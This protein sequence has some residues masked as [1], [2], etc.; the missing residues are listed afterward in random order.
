MVPDD[1]ADLADASRAA[2]RAVRG[3]KGRPADIVV[4][5][6]GRFDERSARPTVEREV[7]QRGLLLYG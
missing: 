6:R 7:A 3:A 4:G 1:R 2:C 5:T